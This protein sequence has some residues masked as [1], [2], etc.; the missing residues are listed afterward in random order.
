MRK[1]L[2]GILVL[3]M[4]MPV[5]GRPNWQDL[6]DGQF[7]FVVRRSIVC[8]WTVCQ[9]RGSLLPTD[10]PTIAPCLQCIMWGIR[11]GE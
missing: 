9:I 3:M 2:V 4:G 1:L 5:M 11:C 6:T 8:L 7:V 10:I